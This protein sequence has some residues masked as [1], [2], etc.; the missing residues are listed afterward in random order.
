MSL[1]PVVRQLLKQTKMFITEK[2]KGVLREQRQDE[3]FEACTF[4]LVCK[5]NSENKKF[6]LCL[7]E[8]KHIQLNEQSYYHDLSFGFVVISN[9]FLAVV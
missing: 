6:K 8:K 4:I 3:G 7:I 2:Y 9:R 5:L 1:A